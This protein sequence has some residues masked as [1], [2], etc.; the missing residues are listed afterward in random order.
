[1]NESAF[2]VYL[3]SPLPC[4]QTNVPENVCTAAVAHADV[5]GLGHCP[6]VSSVSYGQFSAGRM[7]RLRTFGYAA[8]LLA[9]QRP[10]YAAMDKRKA[11]R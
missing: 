6:P 10:Q 1:M 8:Y 5:D 9:P 3:H 4:L 2:F 11:E 7:S